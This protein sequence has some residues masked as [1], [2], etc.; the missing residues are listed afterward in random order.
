ME[1]QPFVI[2]DI[3]IL[4]YN[5]SSNGTNLINNDLCLYCGECVHTYCCNT[6]AIIEVIVVFTFYCQTIDWE[7]SD[8]DVDNRGVSDFVSYKY[9]MF[10]LSQ[11]L[12]RLI[13]KQLEYVVTTDSLIQPE[14]LLCSK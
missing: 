10:T 12:C 5:D 3:N 13:N 9:K 7:S 14:S 2:T 8:E 4:S 11:Y 6:K 1:S